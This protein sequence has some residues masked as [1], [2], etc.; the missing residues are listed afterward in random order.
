[1]A[2]VELRNRTVYYERHGDFERDDR[3][4]LVLIMGMAGSCAGWLPLQVPAFCESRPVLIFENRGVAGSQ[5]PGSAFSTVDL[6]RDTVELMD[7]LE[8]ERAD[9]LGTFMGG[10]TAQELALGWPERVER[11][12]LVGTYARPDTKRRMLLEHWAELAGLDLPAEALVRDRLL[13]TL[14]DETLEQHDLIDA[15]TRFFLRDDTP[16]SADLFARQCRAC[17]EHDA[18]ERLADIS[19]RTLIVCGR[20]DAVTPPKLHRELA[21]LIPDSRL[22]TIGY[23]GHLV[24]VESAERFNQI[25]LQFLEDER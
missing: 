21:A 3:V 5:D 25:V 8:I 2:Y 4:P 9:F 22:V 15:M 13:W 20:R 23:G 14:Q 24:M 6:A 10:M 19:H 16:V 18:Y 11:L 7:A 12:A 1:M 17:I